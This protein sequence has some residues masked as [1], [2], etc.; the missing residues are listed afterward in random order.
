MGR[1]QSEQIP[2]YISYRTF[3]NF[4]TD[5]RSRGVPSRIDRSV[6]SHKSGTVQ[7]QL[8]LAL[9]YLGLVKAT[10]HPTE[11][12]SRLVESEGAERKQVVREMIQSSYDFAFT[13]SFGLE[14]ATSNQAQEIFEQTGASG[15]TVRRCIAFF[16]AAAKDGGIPVSP[17]IKPHGRRRS[18]SRKKGGAHHKTPEAVPSP[19]PASNQGDESREVHLK[20]GGTLKLELSID[21]FDLDQR[22]RDFI[23]K[24]ID[25]LKEYEGEI[26]T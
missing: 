18:A 9:H 5:L 15:E 12:L 25:Q 26:K 24:L 16:L 3:S 22:D 20:S 21:L 23:F 4:L 17:Y 6:M 1:K 10:G 14:T 7:S 11:R 2:P 13:Q 19:S 8:L